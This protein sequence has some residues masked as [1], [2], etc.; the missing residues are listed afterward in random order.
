METRA[1]EIENTGFFAGGFVT[2][3]RGGRAW[4]AAREPADGSSTSCR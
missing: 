4:S 2:G 3:V 1:E